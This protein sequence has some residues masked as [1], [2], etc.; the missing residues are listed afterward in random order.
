MSYKLAVLDD[1][2]TLKYAVEHK[3][4]CRAPSVLGLVVMVPMATSTTAISTVSVALCSMERSSVSGLLAGSLGTRC[5]GRASCAAPSGTPIS[6]SIRMYGYWAVRMAL[7][8][9]REGRLAMNK[10]M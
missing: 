5:G 2:R 10:P 8:L 1:T 4:L 7:P 3:L 9:S 6:I